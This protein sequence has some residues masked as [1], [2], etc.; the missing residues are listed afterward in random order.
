M[1]STES[2]Q[3]AKVLVGK[4]EGTSIRVK[5]QSSPEN[6]IRK[7]SLPME[8]ILCTV[9]HYCSEEGG[10]TKDGAQDDVQR[11]SRCT[12]FALLNLVVSPYCHIAIAICPLPPYLPYYPIIHPTYDPTEHSVH[13][14]TIPQYLDSLDWVIDH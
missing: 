14:T 7:Y 4:E 1:V 6:M 9:A 3:R 10:S 2:K 12:L 11:D 5:L 13:N 8:W